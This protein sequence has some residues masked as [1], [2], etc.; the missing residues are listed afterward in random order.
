M[1]LIKKGISY[2]EREGGKRERQDGRRVSR[3]AYLRLG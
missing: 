2:L 1:S 3:Q